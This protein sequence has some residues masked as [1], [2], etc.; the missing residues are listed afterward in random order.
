MHYAAPGGHVEMSK[1]LVA[2]GGPIEVSDTGGGAFFYAVETN[3]FL[4]V[5]KRAV[6]GVLKNGVAGW[7]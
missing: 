4:F 3:R 5:G 1:L 7:K 2:I 6:T